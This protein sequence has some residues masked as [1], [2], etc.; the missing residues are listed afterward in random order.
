M[1]TTSKL[2]VFSSLALLLGACKPPSL[3]EVSEQAAHNTSALVG[4]A[5]DTAAASTNSSAALSAIVR[6]LN[7]TL[8]DLGRAPLAQPTFPAR[9]SSQATFDT[10]ERFL[11]ERV[12]V[13]ENVESTGLGSVTFLV[14][15]RR[16]CTDPATGSSSSQCARTVDDLQ[17]RVVASGDPNVRMVLDVAFG[18]N[19]IAPVT[20]VLEKDKALEVT[21]RLNEYKR[22][23]DTMASSS[24]AALPLSQQ[25][26]Q[27]D[28]EYRVRLEKL[29]PLDFALSYDV[30]RDVI[31]RSHGSDG[32]LRSTTMGARVPSYRL[33]FDGAHGTQDLSVNLGAVNWTM[34]AGDLNGD[35]DP[36]PFSGTLAG[37]QLELST[38]AAP[39]L[40][41]G[42]LTVLPVHATYGA[43]EVLSVNV[44][45][46]LTVSLGTGSDGR[47]ELSTTELDATARFHLGALPRFSGDP[48]LAD[49]T[50]HLTLLGAHP[51]L[52]LAVVNQALALAVLGARFE[53]EAVSARQ[54]LSA[55]AGQC[56]VA[57]SS[58]AGVGPLRS[59]SSVS[60]P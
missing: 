39:A 5:W 21:L 32:Q 17:L 8:A 23:L 42:Q 28:G 50:L 38:A 41:R 1:T 51:V 58:S 3:E 16:L 26:D 52:R 57:S 33:R 11:K 49:E 46:P 35:A 44:A 29:G 40:A 15:G 47:L 30:T 6:A 22:I 34:P 60:C 36:T 24:S 27:L 9:S 25:L 54:H 45:A 20:L 10:Y 7:L 56:L 31:V 14:D 18:P 53:V 19:R 48:A 55:G 43:T 37:A 59:F 2:I 4:E 13:R 12:F